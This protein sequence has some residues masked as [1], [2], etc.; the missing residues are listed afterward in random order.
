MEFLVYQATGR[1]PNAPDPSR[2]PPV[3]RFA[4][5][6]AEEIVRGCRRSG[7]PLPKIVVEPGRAVV[8][9]AG[10]LL[11]T[12]GSI[13]TRAGVIPWAITDGGA[14]TV[15][16]PLFYEYHEVLH[17][18]APLSPRTR[19]Y[20]L[21]GPVCHSADWIYRNKRMP[22]LAPGDVLAVCDAGAYFLP[23]ES[24]FGFPRPP[25]V[26]VA[27]G[28]ARLLRR[29][30]TFDDLVLRDLGWEGSRERVA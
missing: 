14:G 21:V 26:A 1:L 28:R 27:D 30:E 4:E 16:F 29:R 18:R 9:G 12:V 11:V 17:C 2:F 23:Q 20:S 22:E 6:I 7:W 15:A 25:V 13:K 5:V 24:N 10:L 19:R 8:S 3:S